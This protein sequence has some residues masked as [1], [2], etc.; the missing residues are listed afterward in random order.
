MCVRVR[1]CVYTHTY[2]SHL[3]APNPPL[4]L[5]IQSSGGAPDANAL[6]PGVMNQEAQHYPCL[7]MLKV[8]LSNIQLGKSKQFN[9]K[10]NKLNDTMRKSSVKFRVGDTF[11]DK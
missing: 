11:Q 7:K 4:K 3:L 10:K 5:L 2:L 6:L 9:G 8:N 1:V